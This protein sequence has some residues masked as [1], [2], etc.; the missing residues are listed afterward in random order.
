[1]S[2]PVQEIIA[3]SLGGMCGCFVGYPLDTLK[4]RLQTRSSPHSALW[5]ATEMLKKEGPLSFYRGLSAPLVGAVPINASYFLGYYWGKRLFW[6]PDTIKNNDFAR[7][8]LASAVAGMFVAPVYS[9]VDRMKC[10][11]QVQRVHSIFPNMEFK[12]AY[13]LL[14]YMYGEYG[15]YCCCRGFWAT[16]M[17]DVPGSVFY[18]GTYDWVKGKLSKDG[19]ASVPITMLSGGLGG[20]LYW[21]VVMP[22]DTLKTL[23]QTNP[24]TEGKGAARILVEKVRGEGPF[25]A[26]A[27]LYRGLTPVLLRAFPSNAATFSGYELIKY[28]F[29]VLSPTV[30][31]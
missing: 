5:Y 11:M 12:S 30:E 16:I 23:V 4:V 28:F 3:S 22:M 19:K 13:E 6:N 18:F 2:T 21:V 15:W 25:R 31:P 14:R 1:M 20:M 10:I 29:S 7:I 9:V 17:R 27:S 26:Y 8:A 24:P